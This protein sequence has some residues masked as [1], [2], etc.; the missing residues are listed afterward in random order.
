MVSFS[1]SKISGVFQIPA[2]KNIKRLQE[3]INKKASLE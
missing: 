1:D 2:I 3:T